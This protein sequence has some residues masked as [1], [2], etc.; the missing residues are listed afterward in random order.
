MKAFRGTFH[1]ATAHGGM[2]IYDFNTIRKGSWS[3]SFF[4]IEIENILNFYPSKST[5]N[6]LAIQQVCLSIKGS[7]RFFFVKLSFE[8]KWLAKMH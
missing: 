4:V 7:M 2:I 3:S 6:N 1:I 8:N 5:L